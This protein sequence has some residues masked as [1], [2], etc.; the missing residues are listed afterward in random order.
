MNFKR[1][2]SRHLGGAGVTE[3]QFEP[4]HVVLITWEETEFTVG[5]V[6]IKIKLCNHIIVEELHIVV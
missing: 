5:E 3:D 2:L 6:I 4:V 1:E